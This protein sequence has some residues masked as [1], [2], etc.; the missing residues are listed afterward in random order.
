M[1]TALETPQSSLKWGAGFIGV[2][3]LAVV[4][5]FCSSLD[6][7]AVAVFDERHVAQY[8]M[9]YT[10]NEYFTDLHPPLLKLGFALL[11]N[12]T[13][14]SPAESKRTRGHVSELPPLLTNL[15]WIAASCGVLSVAVGFLTLKAIRVSFGSAVIG[16]SLLALD[17]ALVTQSRVFMLDGPFIL[18]TMLSV[19]CCIGFHLNGQSFSFNWL[20]WLLGLG[21]SLS[22]AVGTKLVALFTFGTVGLVVVLQLWHL[23]RAKTLVAFM[24]HFLSRALLLIM[25]PLSLYVALFWWHFQIL[26]KA[27]PSSGGMSD[28]FTAHLAGNRYLYKNISVPY[29][30]NV[31]LYTV[32]DYA[33]LFFS[34]DIPESSDDRAWNVSEVSVKRYSQFLDPNTVWQFESVVDNY[35]EPRDLVYA[36]IG[37]TVCLKHVISGAYLRLT[38]S[39]SISLDSINDCTATESQWTL[40]APEPQ[41]LAT[42]SVRKG[43][44]IKNVFRSSK[45]HIVSAF[46]KEYRLRGAG[47]ESWENFKSVAAT[48]ETSLKRDLWAVDQVHYDMKESDPA[49]QKPIPPPM[50]FWSKLHHLHERI[51]FLNSRVIQHPQTSSPISWP[52]LVRGIS[53]WTGNDGFSVDTTKSTAQIYLLGNPAI[54][55]LCLVSLVA[56]TVSHTETGLWKSL[57]AA[58]APTSQ[59]NNRLDA[60]RFGVL[61]LWLAWLLHFV[62][63]FLLRRTLFFHHYLPAFSFSV[64]FAVAYIDANRSRIER[65]VGV[66]ARILVGAYIS[67]VAAVFVEFAPLTYGWDI[68]LEEVRRRAWLKTWD[69]RGY[70]EL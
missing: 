65:M 37:D 45:F 8:V 15:R 20:S 60:Q 52:F 28:A 4:T 64:L 44:V 49:M 1:L 70:K 9:M 10:R 26:F 12:A 16:A 30:A 23:S 58:M 11:V 6:H 19:Y 62:P 46:S 31:T 39:N 2:T 35:R 41:N 40:K 50:S 36:R 69:L 63:F 18:A 61:V 66:N 27:G 5:R 67:V 51:V 53:Y 48:E 14:V 13:S 59:D 7:P 25:L 42:P 54:W 21:L 47:I 57:Q 68:S 24:A 38:S 29:N 43:D 55:F 34:S 56:F 32:P 33:H 3:F 17:N 22:V